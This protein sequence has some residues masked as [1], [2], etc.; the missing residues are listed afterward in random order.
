MQQW[1][2]FLHEGEEVEQG[3][4]NGGGKIGKNREGVGG[5]EGGGEKWGCG[6]REQSGRGGG[7]GREAG[8]K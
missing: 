3:E 6:D 5:W 8:E 7:G 2:T 4:R 1:V